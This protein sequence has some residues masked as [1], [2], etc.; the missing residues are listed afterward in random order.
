MIVQLALVVAFWKLETF[1]L[2]SNSVVASLVGTFES[3]TSVF[4][5][6]TLSPVISVV[7]SSM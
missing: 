3:L 4:E 7:G 2:L 6:P 1:V 5:S